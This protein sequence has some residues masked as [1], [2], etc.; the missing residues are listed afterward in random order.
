MKIRD[1]HK[2]LAALIQ[3]LEVSSR[4]LD[5]P[6]WKAVA[7]GL[8]RPRRKGYEVSVADIEKNLGK[9]EKAVVVPGAVL[10]SGEITQPVKV[11]A[12]KF[13][14]SAEEKIRKVGGKCLT[15]EKLLEENPKGEGIRIMG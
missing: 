13:S 11:A 15:I 9:K 4:E 6:V 2:D 5:A 1:K 12:L 7:K 10:G 3:K 14:A 8:N